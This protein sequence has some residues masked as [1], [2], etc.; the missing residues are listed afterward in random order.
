M[1]SAKRRKFVTIKGECFDLEY[2]GN[3]PGT[4]DGVFHDFQLYDVVRNRGVL[5]IAITRGGARDA[6]V[7]TVAEYDRRED[8]VVLNTIRR[9]F[10][11]GTLNF[12]SEGDLSNRLEIALAPSDFSKQSPRTDKDVRSYLIHKAY[13]LAY[14]FPTQPQTAGGWGMPIQF[15]E[16]VDLDYLGLSA[17]DVWRNIRRL[18]NQGLLDKVLEG[19]ARPTEMLLTQY[20]REEDSRTALPSEPDD[21]KFAQL[22]IAEARK[23][24]PEDDRI[25][26]KV[27]VVVVK[28]G[29]IIAS[30]Y[31]GEIPQCHAEY[32]ALEKK[33]SEVPLSNATVFTTLEPCTSR[34]H[35][36][37]PCAIRL[38]ERKIARVV[39]GMLDP[40]DRISGRGQRALRKAEI[41]TDLFPSDL[42][43]QVEELNRDFVRDRESTMSRSED[44]LADEI[45]SY[46]RRMKQKDPNRAFEE[47]MLR[48][49]FG[50]TAEQVARA[51]DVLFVRGRAKQ[52]GFSGT[53]SI[54]P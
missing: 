52:T 31:R 1:I 36:K 16:P 29:Q 19:H 23:S 6:Y 9:A 22:A 38:T 17:P 43:S 7:T 35:P 12:Y 4:R 46:A 33:L 40:D 2:H 11:V 13:W 28:D 32:I 44:A 5:R 34:K 18:E 27:G 54:H 30:A 20:E 51:M 39:I 45:L 25:H 49:E 48:L 10:D 37:V 3:I 8:T 24:I 21:R 50:T 53:W 41:A 14:R 47:A 42:M 15:D 26:P